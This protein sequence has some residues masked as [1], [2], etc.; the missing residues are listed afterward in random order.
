MKMIRSNVKKAF[1]AL[2]VTSLALAA[3]LTYSLVSGHS[4]SAKSAGS[5]SNIFAAT[6]ASAS[7]ATVAAQASGII[8]PRTSVYA[9]DTDNTIFVLV[10]GTTAFV[11]LVRVPDGAVDGNLI[12][13]DFRPADGNNN[14]VYAVT[15]TSKIYRIRLTSSGLGSATLVSTVTPS[16]PS[17]YQSL[18]DFNPVVNAL[19][20][21][22]SDTLNYAVVNNNGNLNTTAVQTALT[23]NTAD[24]ARGISPRVSAGS[25][26]NNV[27]GA[28]VTLFYAID[29]NRDTLVTIDPPPTGG[30]S[31]TGGGVLRTIGNLVAPTG[32]RIK[33]SPT[34]DIDIFTLSNG[35]NRLIGISGRT[36]FTI[37]LA[38]VTPASALGTT[39]NIVANG[40]QMNADTGGRFVDIA[41]ALT[42]YEAENATQGGGN[43]VNS[44]QPGFSGT[45]FVNFA[46][47][48]AN[49]FTEFQVNQA[50][51]QTL[52]FRYANGSA[53]NRPCRVSVNGANV[54]T[55]NFPPTGA[56]TTYR[57]VTLPVSLGTAGGFRS[58]RVTS[59]TAA[60]GPNLDKMNVE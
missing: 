27:N 34:A 60:G 37:D 30:S 47:N 12:G 41:A 10:P 5:P 9:L 13:L 20:L 45:G 3:S 7:A 2:T 25:Y 15:D 14:F 51:T 1:A 26:N 29:Y 46:D 22:G 42:S 57:T 11:S 33:T 32:A 56:F 21:I 49:G 19:R 54:G 17:G 8:M 50:G 23:Y 43:T 52:I 40:I 48:A 53:V 35:A 36:F 16:F 6:A 24:V 28:T 18:T 59:T 38:Q 44:N 39:K 4:T 55:V 58:V 31:A